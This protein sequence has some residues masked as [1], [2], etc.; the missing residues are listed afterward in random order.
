MINIQCQLNGLPLNNPAVEQAALR[1]AAAVHVVCS[2]LNMILFRVMI[3][4][5][6]L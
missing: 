4:Q 3:F 2:V 6:R 5:Q 1:P